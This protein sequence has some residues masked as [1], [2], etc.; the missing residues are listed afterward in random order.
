MYAFIHACTYGRRVC[1]RVR[2]ELGGFESE[3]AG[4]ELEELEPLG[5]V[6]GLAIR[7]AGG[8]EGLGTVPGG[9]KRPR[10][11]Q[12][13]GDEVRAGQVVL[14]LFQG[15]GEIRLGHFLHCPFLRD[16]G[17]GAKE[18]PPYQWRQSRHWWWRCVKMCSFNFHCQ[19]T[20][21]RLVVAF[22][23]IFCENVRQWVPL[24]GQRVSL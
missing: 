15:L 7:R 3:R 1:V 16:I 20:G 24:Q 11:L 23:S 10:F 8:V 4:G 6:L 17:G 13:D 19:T 9:T 21:L 5:G 12:R 22:P 18:T 14:E 2:S